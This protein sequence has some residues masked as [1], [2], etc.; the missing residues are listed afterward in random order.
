MVTKHMAVLSVV[1]SA[2]LSVAV[3]AQDAKPATP[4]QPARPAAPPDAKTALANAAKAMGADSLKTIQYSGAGSNAGIGQNKSPDVDWPLVRVK[5]YVREID[6]AAPS[7][8]TEI[9]RLQNG[10]EAK[11]EQVITP[12]SP[13]DTQYDVWLNPFAFLKGATDVF[14]WHCRNQGRDAGLTYFCFRH[15]DTPE[16]RIRIECIGRDPI[17]YAP[18]I[19]IQDVRCHYLEIIIRCMCKR[20][21]AVAV[22]HRPDPG[23]ISAQLIVDLNIA[24]RIGGDA[25]L[26]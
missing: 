11:Q 10:N 3:L 18:L 21:S 25:S 26:V 19:V 17:G 1:V 8:R 9:V 7:S 5:S 14:H 13:W 16:G 22:S 24:A 4:A 6:F 12:A 2:A 15:A 23:H 20:A